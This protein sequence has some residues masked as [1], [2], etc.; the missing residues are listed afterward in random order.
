VEKRFRFCLLTSELRRFLDYAKRR[1]EEAVRDSIRNNFPKFIEIMDSRLMK[2]M[3]KSLIEDR[4]SR[5]R[6][7]SDLKDTWKTAFDLL[8]YTIEIHFQYGAKLNKSIIDKQNED[9]RSF[10]HFHLH[11]RACQIACEILTLL[12]GGYA[13]GAMARWRSLYEI[14]VISTFLHN[15]PVDI[16]ERYW[17]YSIVED[18]FELLE[19]QKNYLKLGVDSVTDEEISASNKE[20]NILKDKYGDDYIKPY[21]WIGKYLEKRYWNF[22]GIEQTVEFKFMRSHYKWANNCIHSGPKSIRSKLGAP[23]DNVMLAGPSNYGFADPAQ[24]TAYSLLQIATT[25]S[26]GETRFEDI[27]YIEIFIRMF[28]RVCEEFVRIQEQIESEN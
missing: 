24:N 21:G 19:L 28:E 13:D 12:E 11:A 9:I 8:E 4:K 27:I 7:F 3:K 16:F 22:S 15:K 14:S 20:I 23:I 2:K 25:L 6:F 18:H 26:D 5:K 1:I 10:V 17:N